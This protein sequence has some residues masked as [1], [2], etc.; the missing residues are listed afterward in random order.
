MITL[1]SIDKNVEFMIININ[2]GKS[3]K[4]KLYTMGVHTNDCYIKTIGNGV[5]GPVIIQ[6]KSNNSTQ[7]AIG[8]ELA[9]KIIVEVKGEE[10]V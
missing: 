8:R 5:G 4:H 3:A 7:I 9:D 6:N 10:V 1:L 2:S